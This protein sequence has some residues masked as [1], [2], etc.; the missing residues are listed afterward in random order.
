MTETESHQRETTVDRVALNSQTHG[1]SVKKSRTEIQRKG[2]TTVAAS[3]GAGCAAASI[4]RA[5]AI[6]RTQENDRNSLNIPPIAE[7]STLADS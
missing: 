1:N 2:Y 4:R 6:R 3:Q 7:T 5:G